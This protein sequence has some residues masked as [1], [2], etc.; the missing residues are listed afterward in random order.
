[1]TD[2][3]EGRASDDLDA[4]IAAARARQAPP[5]RQVA[6]SALARGTR[7]AAEIA[8]ATVVGFG[9]GW[10]LDGQLGTG[11]WLAILF[12]LLGVAAGFRNLLR[13]VEQ[14]TRAVEAEA[15]ADG[16]D[17]GGGP[18]GPARTE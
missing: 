5:P 2:P 17:K 9:L 8:V 3:A 11:P 13:A 16:G 4:R 6:A 10:F 14:E 1:M 15:A 18:G 7:Y 12:L